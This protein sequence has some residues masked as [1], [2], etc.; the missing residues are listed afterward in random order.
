MNLHGLR[1]FYIVAKAG[2]VT[3]AAEQ[4]KISQPAITAQI[5]KFE[6]ENGI[7]LFLPQG[8]GIRL[9]EIGKKVVEE[10]DLI[11]KIENR[12]E[13]LIYNY[14]QGKNGT[15]KIAGNYLSTNFLIP[16]WV[17][18]LK[19]ENE[20]VNIEI[21][22]MNTEDAIRHLISYEVDVAILGSGAMKYIDKINSIKIMDDDLWFVASTNHKYANKK[23]S[24]ADIMLEPFIM[25]EKGSYARIFLES[26]CYTYGIRLPKIAI[27]FNGLHETLMASTFGYGV[28]FCSS[29]AAKE[30]IDMRKLSRIYID[31]INLK[32]KI[33]I[34]VRKNE[35]VPSLVKNFI[36]VIDS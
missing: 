15:L 29:I 12:I 23:V 7:T 4:L 25:R 28:S 27:E 1:L 16:M 10:A 34:C 20:D 26:L 31:N 3:V 22:T 11:F 30:F 24:L 33:V 36:S 19:Q 21:N 9:S 2:S 13:T 35:E 6:K 14:K 17:T 32:N 18:K 5:K 8:R